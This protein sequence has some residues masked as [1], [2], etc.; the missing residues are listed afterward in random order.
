MRLNFIACSHFPNTLKT[1]ILFESLTNVKVNT[2]RR[3]KT[4]QFDPRCADSVYNKDALMQAKSLNL[5]HLG[6]ID[7]LLMATGN[8]A[9][10]DQLRLVVYP[11]IFEVLAPSQVV[12]DFF[13]QQYVQWSTLVLVIGVDGIR[14]GPPNEGKD[15]T[16]YISGIYGQSG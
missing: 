11:I 9:I 7:L 14:W 10:S 13:H 4:H 5:S 3:R 15:Y 12:Q 8:L 2:W 16:W 6:C 1:L